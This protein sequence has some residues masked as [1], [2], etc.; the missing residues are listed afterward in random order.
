MKTLAFQW[1]LRSYTN[2]P[3]ST[4]TRTFESG[5]KAIAEMF[6]RF[7]NGRVRDL[8]LCMVSLHILA[9]QMETDLLHE[10]KHR[11][12][13]PHRTQHGVAIR[14]EDN[15]SLSVYRSAEV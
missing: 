6:F 9:F 12:P 4:L 8:L 5:L 1:T 7:S 15:V 14:S 10:V 11:N 2:T 13:I 3:S